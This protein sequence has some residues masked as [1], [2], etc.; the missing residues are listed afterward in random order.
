MGGEGRFII[1]TWHVYH[2]PTLLMPTG[3]HGPKLPASQWYVDV[4]ILQE[5]HGIPSAGYRGSEGS[6]VER[7]LTYFKLSMKPYEKGWYSKQ[8]CCQSVVYDDAWADIE[9]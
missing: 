5:S 8:L 9:T 7:E 3:D 2:D 1:E 4:S 6:I